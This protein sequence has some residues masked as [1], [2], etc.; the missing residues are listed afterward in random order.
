MRMA[1][2]FDTTNPA[3]GWLTHH[4]FL[5]RGRLLGTRTVEYDVYRV[6]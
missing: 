4:L 3:Y 5:A 6:D 1:M 2:W